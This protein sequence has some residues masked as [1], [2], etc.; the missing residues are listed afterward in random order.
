MGTDED[1]WADLMFALTKSSQVRPSSLAPTWH[2][3]AYSRQYSQLDS[4]KSSVSTPLSTPVPVSILFVPGHPRASARVT[5][6][7]LAVLW[8]L[9]SSADLPNVLAPLAYLML[10]HSC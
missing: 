8:T 5:S 3:L 6:N 7:P 2:G 9:E 1:T 10:P 4:I